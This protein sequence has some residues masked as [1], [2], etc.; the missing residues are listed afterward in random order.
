M[1][2]SVSNIAWR[3]EE[4]KKIAPVL[5]DLGVQLLE[6][7]PTRNW[8]DPTTADIQE[9]MKYV[10]FWKSYGIK[11]IAFQS[12]LFNRPD[13]K[14]FESKANL[15]QTKKYLTDFIKVAGSLDVGIMVFGSPK[16]RQRGIVEIGKADTIARDFFYSL[17]G[18][19][20]KAGVIFCIEPNATEYACDYI[21][22]AQEGA[23]LVKEVDSRGFGLHLDLACMTL[24]GDDIRQSIVDAKGIL[25]HFHISEPMLGDVGP[26][27]I[28]QHR[29][30]ARALRDIGYQGVVSIE[31]RPKDGD[32]ITRVQ[33]AVEF[34]K[35]IY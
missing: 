2:L 29:E 26:E 18:I 30:A 31:M 4:D 3:K 7:A 6:I 27:S 22:N 11:V 21:T 15:E 24:A 33:R 17:G 20:E 23:R 14:I 32:N 10:S 9:V 13:L 28:L 16:N 34:A 12:M 8:E 5:R 35:S 25:R 1:K 19:A